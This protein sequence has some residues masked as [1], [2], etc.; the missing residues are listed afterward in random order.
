MVLNPNTYLGKPC[1][2]NHI[3]ESTQKSLRYKSNSAC[4]ECVRLKPKNKKKETQDFV[5]NVGNLF[6]LGKLCPRNHDH[7]S[8][9]RSLR[10]KSNF[11]CETVLIC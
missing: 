1:T 7:E 11:D 6:Y 9:G 3:F 8:T 2:L 4:L 5:G 10:Y